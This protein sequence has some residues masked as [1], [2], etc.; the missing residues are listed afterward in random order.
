LV[1]VGRYLGLGEHGTVRLSELEAAAEGWVG[2]DPGRRGGDRGTARQRFLRHGTGWPR[3]AGRLEVAAVLVTRHADIVSQ[4]VDYMRR[5]AGRSAATVGSYRVR[6]K[7]FLG[8][9]GPGT[10]MVADITLADVDSYLGARGA[11]S[12]CSPITLRSDVAALRAFFRLAEHRGRRARGLSEA[13][14]APRV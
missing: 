6:T 13:I 1:V 7:E 12:G 3:F 5:E 14:T 10:Q 8:W 4:F 9:L 11:P 2:Q